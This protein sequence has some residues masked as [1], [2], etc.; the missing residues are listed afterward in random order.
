MPAP[1]LTS[2]PYLTDS[3]QYFQRIRHLSHPAWLDSCAHQPGMASGRYDILTAAPNELIEVRH[4]QCLHRLAGSCPES[5]E[6]PPFELLQQRLALYSQ[7]DSEL[8]FCGGALGLFGY[9]LKAELEPNHCPNTRHYDEAELRVGIYLWA[10]IQ[11]H[12][13][14]CSQLVFHPDCDSDFRNDI[15]SL[16]EASTGTSDKNDSSFQLQSPF[17]CDT[18]K[19]QYQ[20]SFDK[21][22]NYI[23]A[24]D[25]YQI[26]YTQRFSSQY[27]GDPFTAYQ[28][29]RRTS[30]APFS[31]YLENPE[32]AILS[33]SPERFLQSRKGLVESKPIKGTAPRGTSPGEDQEKAQQL[34]A[35]EKDRAENLMIVDL[36]R[37]DLGRTCQ[38][39]SVRVPQLF[40]LESYANVHH[41]VSTIQGVLAADQSPLTLYTHAFPGGSITGAPKVRAMEIIDE[42]EDYSRSI[43]CGSIAYISFNQQMDS[44][45]CIRTLLAHKGNLYCWGG[46]GIVADSQCDGEREE[47]FAKVRNLVYALEQC[48]PDGIQPPPE[49]EL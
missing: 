41:L 26:N 46:G 14:G 10:L 1:H 24:G 11:D 47:S 25:C 16:L 20:H 3:S 33:H 21:I 44:S 42:L 17:N 48:L 2:V 18:S 32:G 49:R 34:L 4:G 31:A 40:G 19:Q 15:V 43:Y 22:Q 27:T 13:T 35:S 29:L 30:P 6:I 5:L 8:P 28:R 23:Q 9:E 45:I 37:N 36:L 39:G 7:I 38:P 12:Q